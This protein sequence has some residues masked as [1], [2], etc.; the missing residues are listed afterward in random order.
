MGFA[1]FFLAEY[2]NIIL[3]SALTS[4]LFLGGWWSLF[5]FFPFTL[6]PT[7][8]WLPLKAFFIIYGFILVR[9]AFPR[10]RYDMLMRLGWKVLL[11]FSLAAVTLYAA[12]LLDF[13]GGV[14]FSS[15]FISFLFIYKP[16]SLS[17]LKKKWKS[18]IMFFFKKLIFINT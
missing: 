13:N 18:F 3:M 11:P 1:L 15:M 14:E 8:L 10:Y 9:G 6:V 16:Y 7:L 4:L 12:L 5:E 17:L 2:G